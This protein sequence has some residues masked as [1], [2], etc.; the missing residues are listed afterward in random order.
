MMETSK[1]NFVT[2]RVNVLSGGCVLN[3]N[4]DIYV[5]F[6]DDIVIGQIDS[7]KYTETVPYDLTCDSQF[8]ELYIAFE[9]VKG[10]TSNSL[11]VAD[12]PG[13][14]IKLYIDNKPMNIGSQYEID[15][16]QYLPSL[17]AELALANGIRPIGDCEFLPD[18]SF[19]MAFTGVSNSKIKGSLRIDGDPGDLG[20]AI[21]LTSDKG[22]MDINRQYPITGMNGNKFPQVIPLKASILGEED[23]IKN[24]SIKLGEFS[25]TTTFNIFTNNSAVKDIMK[26][27]ILVCLLVV[28]P[29]QFSRAEFAAQGELRTDYGAWMDTTYVLRG[30]LEHD[31][32]PLA[33]QAS[34]ACPCNIFLGSWGTWEDGQ[35]GAR[36]QHIVSF[37]TQTV[38]LTERSSWEEKPVTFSEVARALQKDGVLIKTFKV[39]GNF[40]Q[41]ALQGKVQ[42]VGFRP[43]VWQLAHQYALN[44]DVCNDGEGVLVRLLNT[45]DIDLF[46]QLLYQHCPP[47]AHIESVQ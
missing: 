12:T 43:Y 42:G 13:L 11:K 10:E 32:R 34:G 33:I 14:N 44:G 27:L 37:D 15:N 23:A 1:S 16:I 24:K 9:G 22:N 40:T 3:N 2:V 38:K 46:T 35:Y 28:A 45:A 18:F 6:G 41:D 26:R 25:A 20:Y 7:G 21:M 30:D 17:T 29:F 36:T 31:N 4:E 8:D 5:D 19:S 39:A 47:L